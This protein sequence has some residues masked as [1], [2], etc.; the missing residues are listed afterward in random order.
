MLQSIILINYNELA[1]HNLC[2]DG[3]HLQFTIIHHIYTET[4]CY[5][6]DPSTQTGPCLSSIPEIVWR[7][8][9][10]TDVIPILYES[11]PLT[12][13][14]HNTLTKLEGEPFNQTTTM[15]AML[16]RHPRKQLVFTHLMAA[17]KTTDQEDLVKTLETYSPN[18][19]VTGTL[20]Y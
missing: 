4:V 6:L 20:L 7:E 16:N 19:S 14:Q 8:I 17:L 18:T 3:N 12:D 11:I 13:R 10:P 1:N 15:M 2:V 5:L 9:K